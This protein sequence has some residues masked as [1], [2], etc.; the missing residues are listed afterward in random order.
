MGLSCSRRRNN[1]IIKSDSMSNFEDEWEVIQAQHSVADNHSSAHQLGAARVKRN[2]V[3]FRK[4]VKKIIQLLTY[5]RIWSHV[6][7]MLQRPRMPEYK[8]RPLRILWNHMRHRVIQC[9]HVFR[10]LIRVKGK[11]RHI[12]EV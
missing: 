4:C 8:K 12:S 10:H 5:R 9:S 11:L 2:L 7:N 1:H 6:G 3:K